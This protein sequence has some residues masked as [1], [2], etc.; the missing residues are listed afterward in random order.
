[1]PLFMVLSLLHVRRR[2]SNTLVYPIPLF[3]L[4]V[5]HPRPPPLG[6]ASS[7]VVFVTFVLIAVVVHIV[8]AL[9][10][11]VFSLLLQLGRYFDSLEQVCS[12][13]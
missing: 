10:V 3:L 7:V 8:V 9:K 12:E 5:L 6:A 1:M 11:L 4:V 2:E 13:T